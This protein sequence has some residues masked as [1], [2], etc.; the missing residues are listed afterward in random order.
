MDMYAMGIAS[1]AVQMVNQNATASGTTTSTGVDFGALLSGLMGGD[2]SATDMTGLMGMNWQD[3]QNGMMLDA[4]KTMMDAEQPTV[5]D[6]VLAQ[7]M[8]LLKQAQ[9]GEGGNDAELMELIE[10][11]QNRLR[12]MLEENGQQIAGQQALALFQM[13]MPQL[14][15]QNMD[16][17]LLQTMGADGGSS[18]LQMMVNNSPEALLTLMNSMPAQTASTGQNDTATLLSQMTESSDG[19]AAGAMAQAT[20]KANATAMQAQAQAAEVTLTEGEAP[21]AA[22]ASSFEAAVRTA[23]QQLSDHLDIDTQAAKPAEEKLDIDALQQKV[24]T[25]AYLKGTPLAPGGNAEQTLAAAPAYQPPEVQLTQNI[26]KAISA[27]QEELTVKLNPEELGEVTIK[28]TKSTEG[29]Q[30]S[31]IAKNPET[32]ALLAEQ[33]DLIKASMKPLNVEVGEVLSQQQY[34]MLNQQ[35]QQRQQQQQSL[36][37]AAYYKDEPLAAGEAAEAITQTAAPQSA[38]NTLI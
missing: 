31:L 38:L 36:Q 28:L 11:M 27:G 22:K 37:G 35:N 24:D 13:L 19:T 7:L 9:G 4:L 10:R 25:G 23:K 29:M 33:L 12:D 20:A 8:E 34:E 26:Q 21:P 16:S 32:Q 18:L 14:T 15:G 6:P 30:L 1:G 17:S 2:A 3:I 5:T